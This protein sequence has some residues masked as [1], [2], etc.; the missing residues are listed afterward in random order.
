VVGR[1]GTPSV[2]IRT[3]DDHS[4][5]ID[6]S[7]D[8]RRTDLILSLKTRGKCG[9]PQVEVTGSTYDRANVQFCGFESK[10]RQR[11]AYRMMFHWMKL[12][13]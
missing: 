3:L 7:G 8:D 12:K 2:R 10:F 4:A 1:W 11:D 6:A 13:H 5:R 9:D